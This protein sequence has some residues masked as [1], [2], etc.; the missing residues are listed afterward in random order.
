MNPGAFG[1]G[2]FSIPEGSDVIQGI[3]DIVIHF[4]TLGAIGFGFHPKVE[5]FLGVA[6]RL[7]FGLSI[8]GNVVFCN[9]SHEPLGFL[10][11]ADGECSGNVDLHKLWIDGSIICLWPRNQAELS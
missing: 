7:V 8:R 1:Y 11:D 2:L 4:D 9:R 3:L 6:E 10:V 5:G